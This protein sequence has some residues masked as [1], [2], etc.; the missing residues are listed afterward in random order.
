MRR[1]IA[2]ILLSLGVSM[3]IVD[4]TIVNVIVPVLVRDLRLTSTD[5]QWVNEVYSLVFAA[6]LL[7]SGSLADRLGRRRIFLLGVGV[8]AVASVACA[9]AQRTP[10]LIGGRVGQG[11]G[12]AMILPTSLSLINA[13][14]R[15][16]ERG[17]AFAVWGSTIG[18]TAALGPLIGGWLA[19]DASWR[20]AFG[21]NV[22]VAL[23]IVAVLP[24][25]LHESRE[26]V[27]RPGLDVLG[28]L[29]SAVGFAALVF[30]LI[31]GRT[32]GWWSSARPFDLGGFAWNAAVSPIPVAFAVAA[33]VLGGFVIYERRRRR[34][35]RAVLLDLD[36]LRIE[37]FR[38]G[39]IA[40]M[41]VSLGEFGLLFALPL[42]LQ[43]TLG[44]SALRTGVALLP[45][46]IGSFLASGIAQPLT[47]RLGAVAVVRLGIVAEI[48]GVGGLGL[49]IGA[50]TPWWATAI[51]LLVYGVG[52]GLAT[53]QLTGIV[54]ADVPVDAGGQASGTQ[55]VSRQIGSA[56]GIAVLG[57]VLFSRL[58]AGLAERLAG[59]PGGDRIADAVG[60]SA[61][62]AISG[63][64]A[65][66]ATAAAATAARLAL[67]HAASVTAYTAAGF[68]LL[69]LLATRTLGP[70][71]TSAR[72]EPADAPAPQ[73]SR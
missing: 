49:V 44:Y 16:R 62:G 68:L 14:F 23:V 42:W 18:A 70:P 24:V 27:R 20:W 29:L 21:V 13:T 31:E 46:A 48:A 25:V 60:A 9:L 28:S 1:W 3:I 67:A 7:T 54:L 47:G 33:L 50:D 8:F 58:Q 51:P 56:L 36:L 57:T 5:T 41:V 53:A 45:L 71:R 12:G 72:L 2:L 55:S 38:N 30:A 43:Y 15:G 10:A 64:A 40:A 61:G 34:T 32:Y 17:I 35:G 26:K 39:N 37:S 4:A 52:V 6:L 69:G 22:P 19:T 59:T 65:D 73:Q 66:P 11:I 63:L